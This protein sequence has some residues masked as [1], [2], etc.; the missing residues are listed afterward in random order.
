MYYNECAAYYDRLV[1]QC[2]CNLED[3][4]A[5][6]LEP[7]LGKN[8]THLPCKHFFHSSCLNQVIEAKTYTCPLCRYNL[9]NSLYQIGHNF[10]LNNT[11]NNTIN[12]ANINAN[13]TTWDDLFFNIIADYVGAASEVG[14][15]EVGANEVGAN[16]A[17]ASEVGA[18]EVGT[19]EVGTNEVG[20]NE[21]GANEVGANEVG[22]NEVEAGAANIIHAYLIFYTS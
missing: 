21:V 14:A 2:K 11:I 17:G 10:F 22:T 7:L 18:S 20:P 19:N 15:S 12:N 5:V 8:V 13:D 16:E 6:C 4:C 3:D 1:I 9:I